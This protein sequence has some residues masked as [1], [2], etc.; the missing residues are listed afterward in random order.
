MQVIGKPRQVSTNL[1]HGNRRFLKGN[2][3]IPITGLLGETDSFSS[4]DLW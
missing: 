1:L 3:G 4:L 2:Y